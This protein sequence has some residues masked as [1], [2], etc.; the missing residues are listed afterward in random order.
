[1]REL[2]DRFDVT[3]LPRTTA[4]GYYD[5]NLV[6]AVERV[7]DHFTTAPAHL[8]RQRV[9][10][11]RATAV[12]LA[13]GAIERPIAYANNDLPGTMLAGA[14][15]TYVKR[16]GVRPGSRAVIFANN[17]GALAD[18]LALQAAGVQVR[19]IV[20]ARPSAPL[21]RLMAN[22]IPVFN[23]AEILAASGKQHVESVDVAPLAG[24]AKQT[25]ECDLVAVSGGW[26]PAVHLF[27]Q[28]RGK[29]RYDDAIA[30]FVP[31]ASSQPIFPAG[32][33]N[34]CFDLGAALIEGHNAG[35][36][37]S[38]RAGLS[39]PA[40]EPPQSK[41]HARSALR[42]MWS[43][44]ARSK[45]GKRFVDLQNDVTVNDIALAAREGYQSIEHLKRYT[46]LG[47][48][49]DQGKTSNI[50]GLALMAQLLDVP[51]PKVG[52]TTFRPP[53]TPVTLGAI[54][55]H[56]SRR[57]CRADALFI[58]SRLARDARRPVCKRRAMEA[59]AFVSA[60]WRIG[61]RCGESRSAQR[62]HPCRRGRCVH[63][64]QDRTAGARC[65]RVAQSRLHQQVGHT[66]GRS[67]PLRRD[68]AR[69]RHG[70]GRRH[71]VAACQTRTT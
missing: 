57:A 52:T 59:P 45:S 51:I 3:L 62:P 54:P 18:A 33:A 20:D 6:G 66:R 5:G 23:E 30:A 31:E 32:A 14:A 44:R 63:T 2:R 64:R 60:F 29:L 36:A 1:M 28:A 40:L 27:S 61:R 46:T 71:N 12:V 53:Y 69:R 56:E 70:D 22:R 39:A 4:F 9:W 11:I 19:A 49:T 34:G 68:A 7:T 8:P 15:R 42:P 26:S 58:D 21:S 50:V 41:R 37:A 43:V 25:V 47:M 13:S 17:D 38:T 65:R 10:K 55:G 16:Y 67:L 24:G 35:V 48:G